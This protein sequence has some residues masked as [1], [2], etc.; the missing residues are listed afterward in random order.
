MVSD[1]SEE[2][3][4][5]QGFMHCVKDYGCRIEVR[6]DERGKTIERERAEAEVVFARYE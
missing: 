3:G 1:V 2:T 6:G 4:S 5:S